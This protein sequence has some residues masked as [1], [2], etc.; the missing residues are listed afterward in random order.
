M[1][2]RNSRLFAVGIIL[3]GFP[4]MAQPTPAVINPELGPKT[5]G[6]IQAE[7]APAPALTE[8]DRSFQFN[9]TDY[10]RQVFDQ[11]RRYKAATLLMKHRV[12]YLEQKQKQDK[13]APADAGPVVITDTDVEKPSTTPV[14]PK[15]AAAPSPPPP[16]PPPSYTVKMI[17]GV[18]DDMTAHMVLP[19][20]STRVVR[21]GSSLIGQ[22]KVSAITSE[23][24]VINQGGKSISL[25]PSSSAGSLDLDASGFPP[26][27]SLPQGM[28]L[29]IKR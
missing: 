20:G 2:A 16:P 4:V 17:V 19:G 26:V 1:I 6:V 25:Y 29:P 11:V 23:K 22:D 10:E 28:P 18:M 9:N 5:P 13:L 21:A 27:P 15:V 7:R 24:V 8:P 12:D 3:A 14:I